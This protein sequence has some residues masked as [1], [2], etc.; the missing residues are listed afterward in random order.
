MQLWMILLIILAITAIA[1]GLLYYFG[2]KMQKKQAGQREQLEA[3]AQTVSMLVIDKKRMK[4]K[5]SGLPKIVIEQ[6]PRYLRGS[7]MPIVKAKVG[8]K[9][10]TLVADEGIYDQIPIKAE[11][12]ATVSGIYIIGVKNF[13][14]AAVDKPLKKGLIAKI[15][16]KRAELVSRLT[17]DKKATTKKK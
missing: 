6:T 9:V 14:N 2:N 1:L 15:G 16:R 5:E 7:K 13:R 17:A 8:P 12:K 11:I 3:A 10:M 4:L